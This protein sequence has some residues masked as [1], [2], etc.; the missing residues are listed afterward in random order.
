MSPCTGKMEYYGSS[1]VFSRRPL[2][3]KIM[4]K[5]FWLFWYFDRKLYV[6]LIPTINEKFLRN[7]TSFEKSFIR[8]FY[9][10]TEF[11]EREQKS[12]FYYKNVNSV[13]LHY[14]SSTAK[15]SWTIYPSP[16][17]GHTSPHFRMDFSYTL[18]RNATS[19]IKKLGVDFEYIFFLLKNHTNFCNS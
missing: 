17:S 2:V 19:S 15:T 9:Y 5:K 10:A 1:L 6:A 16:F 4:E 3:K 13:Y 11:H 7:I 12:V 14:A 18:K 8:Y